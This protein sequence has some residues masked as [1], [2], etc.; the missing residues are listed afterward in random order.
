M[1]AAAAVLD[2]AYG[3]EAFDFLTINNGARTAALGNASAVLLSSSDGLFHNPATM[4]GMEHDFTLTVSY[5]PLFFNDSYSLSTAALWN[6][7]GV[8]RINPW[9]SVGSFACGVSYGDIIGNFT[10]NNS[11]GE[12]LAASSLCAGIGA[13][14]SIANFI[15][16]PLRL[17]IGA[18]GKYIAE[19]IDRDTMFGVSGSAG[20]VAS[21]VNVIPYSD[22]SLGIYIRDLG[23]TVSTFR[24]IVLPAAYI[25]GI[26]YA[27]HVF[28]SMVIRVMCDASLDASSRLAIAGGV[29]YSLMQM[30]FLRGGCRYD[31]GSLVPSAGCGVKYTI[32]GQATVGVDYAAIMING[33]G[34]RHAIQT[35]FAYRFAPSVTAIPAIKSKAIDNQKLPVTNSSDS[36]NV[37]EVVQATKNEIPQT[38]A[39]EDDELLRQGL[40]AA[41]A[42]DYARAIDLWSKIPASSSLYERA[43]KNIQKAQTALNG[44]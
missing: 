12:S 14:V 15:G 30:L 40:T 44:E 38:T 34:I 5:D 36:V 32:G 9:L 4:G 19:T 13:A 23:G 10:D 25:A 6:A 39:N 11:V 7:G 29:E 20:C 42:K 33:F 2:G 16:T 28:D 17:D 3:T 8:V 41:K 18:M 21:L 35:E 37:K 22:L 31:D 26:G 24:N 27:L 1:I 43:Q